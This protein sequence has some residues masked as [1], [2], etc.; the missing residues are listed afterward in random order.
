MKCLVVIHTEM[1]YVRNGARYI[2][3]IFD[4]I[5]LAITEA[6]IVYYLPG[7]EEIY[8]RIGVLIPRMKV[9]PELTTR[10]YASQFLAAKERAIAEGITETVISGIAYGCCVQAVHRLFQGGPVLQGIAYFRREHYKDAAELMR[11]DEERFERVIKTRIS[12]SIDRILTD[13]K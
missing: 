13:A 2:S 3:D 5:A 11:W 8:P 4:R 10:S 6:P 9:M 7:G 1:N 12:S